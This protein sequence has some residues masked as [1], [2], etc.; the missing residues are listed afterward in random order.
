[1]T[2]R[3]FQVAARAMLK[4]ALGEWWLLTIGATGVTKRVRAH[5]IARQE[6]VAVGQAYVIT[7]KPTL[8]LESAEVIGMRDGDTILS[9]SFQPFTVHNPMDNGG[10][11]VIVE[12]RKAAA[13]PNP[14]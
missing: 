8:I 5:E 2:A 6:E 4:T 13:I 10:G 3:V 9:P 1:M 12:I 7:S 14:V 11:N